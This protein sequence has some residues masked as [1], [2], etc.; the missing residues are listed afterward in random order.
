MFRRYNI[1]NKFV[2]YL[3]YEWIYVKNDLIFIDIIKELV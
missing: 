2:F 3:W 1:I